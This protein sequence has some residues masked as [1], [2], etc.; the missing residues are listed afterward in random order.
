MADYIN[1]HSNGTIV[2]EAF[3]DTA[4][5]DALY[6]KAVERKFRPADGPVCDIAAARVAWTA[7]L[8]EVLGADGAEGAFSLRTVY[9]AARWIVR[10]GTI[11]DLRTFGRDPVA[12]RMF[13]PRRCSSPS[14]V[15]R[16]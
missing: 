4:L 7:A 2:A 13:S 11:G 8:D 14:S 16:Q 5:G 15:S 1:E 10:R 9:N 12:S 3:Y 6:S